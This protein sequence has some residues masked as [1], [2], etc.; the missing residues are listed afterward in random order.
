VGK[1]LHGFGFSLRGAR[2][3]VLA[4]MCLLGVIAALYAAR[5]GVYPEW[6]VLFWASLLVTS[7]QMFVFAPTQRYKTVMFDLPGLAMIVLGWAAAI[8]GGG[9]WSVRSGEGQAGRS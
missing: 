3:V 4:A 9:E 2:D 7:V 1:V 5:V 8:S 6:R